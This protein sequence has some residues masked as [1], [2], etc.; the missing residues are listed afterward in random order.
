MPQKK[1]SAPLSLIE[2]VIDESYKVTELKTIYMTYLSHFIPESRFEIKG[3]FSINK[4]KKHQLV[5]VMGEVFA[6]Q[7]G[8]DRIYSL[9]PTGVKTVLKILVWDA[10]EIEISDANKLHPP[11]ITIVKEKMPGGKT[12]KTQQ[13][14]DK[15]LIIPIDSEYDW[16][17]SWGNY[18]R[19]FFYLPDMLRETFKK[20]LP[21]PPEYHL[22]GQDKIKETQFYFSD[23]ENVFAQI[24]V[25]DAYIRQG[26]LKYAKNSDNVLKTSMCR[27]VESCGLKEFYPDVDK[28]LDFMR[29]YMMVNL[30]S[31]AK[32]DDLNGATPKDL[33]NAFKRFF[34]GVGFKSYEMANL[35]T[36][37]K[38][39]GYLWRS[40]GFNL[41]E[42]EK[43]ARG[44]LSK[45]I[46][47]LPT[48]GWVSAES[49]IK[50][51]HYRN[52]RLDVIRR[53]EAE[54]YVY[55]NRPN[56]FGKE[57]RHISRSIYI[58]AVVE[59]FV[60]AAMFL[61]ASFGLVEIAYNMPRNNQL[62]QIKKNYLS[63]YDGLEYVRLTPL[64]AFV[65]GKLK[66]YK[67]DTARKMAEVTL[68]DNR[69]LIHLHGKDPIKEMT[70][71]Q[72]ADPVS[73]RCYKVSFNSFLRGCA[74]E[75]DIQQRKAL[76]KRH[77][78]PKPAGIWKA[79]LEDVEGKVDPLIPVKAMDVF[80]L[81]DNAEL[82]SLAARDPELRK[83]ILKA[84]N[85][86][87]LIPH[88]HLGKVKKRLE[89]FGYLLQGW[90]V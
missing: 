37:L 40:N 57:K 61:F 82:I 88:N 31:A 45:V 53:F 35:L 30:L 24:E 72:F 34:R 36:H 58:P 19:Y 33:K 77:I 1:Q 11:T 32:K 15:Y 42:E 56:K 87:I 2:S 70:L 4:V 10:E 73:D 50:H 54:Q 26:Q 74:T 81:K 86:H 5:T 12:R 67:A 27:M 3:N 51:C 43:A 46:R 25:L 48:S 17:S 79:F 38:G 55:Y 52:Y 76:F 75:S 28:D 65:A 21:A 39:R 71:T 18:R 22:E 8:F 68:D 7:K 29:G 44:G 84:E 69:L 49:L 41:S 16:Q 14:N 47:A 9:M 59:P 85:H 20:Y 80:Q 23:Q 60:K 13:I 64:G 89:H 6:T 66:S 90:M 62:Q 83:Y 78:E 63:I